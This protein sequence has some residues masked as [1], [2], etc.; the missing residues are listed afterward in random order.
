M[1]DSAPAP[2]GHVLVV[3][4]DPRVRQTIR[5]A[6]EDEGLA[7]ETAADGR[8]ALERA[9]ARRPALVVLDLTLP[10]LD[11]YD[12]ANGLRSFYGSGVPILAITADG[13]A[14]Q[15][16]RRAGAYGYLS[17]PFE[18]DDLMAAVRRG[19]ARPSPPALSQR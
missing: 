17:K 16:A 1:S 3:D 2:G 13:D 11:G 19:L 4:D 15:K 6:L 14:E 5:W 18:L 8:R 7:V 9:S 12:V 10:I